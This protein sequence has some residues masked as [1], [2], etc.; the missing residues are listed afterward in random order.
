MENLGYIAIVA[1]LIFQHLNEK[2]LRNSRKVCQSWKLYLDHPSSPWR[3]FQRKKR[4][5]Q[6]FRRR[7]KSQKL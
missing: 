6:K 2:D 5:M 4:I 7:R 3:E 1:D